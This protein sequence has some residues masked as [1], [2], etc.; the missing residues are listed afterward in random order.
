VCGICE[1]VGVYGVWCM[2]AVCGVCMGVWCICVSGECASGVC[3]WCM[4]VSGML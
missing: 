4:Y 3:V 1:C 2:S